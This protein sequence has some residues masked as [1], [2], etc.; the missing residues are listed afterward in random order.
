MPVET[1][2]PPFPPSWPYSIFSAE[3]FGPNMRM[4]RGDTFVFSR[5]VYDANG[6]VVDITGMTVRL[7][8]KYAVTDDDGD[9]VFT[10][11]TGGNGIV[12]TTPASGIYTVTIDPEDTEDLPSFPVNLV[13]DIQLIDGSTV[14][15]IMSGVLTVV[16]DVG[17]T[18]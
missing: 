16:P 12:L 4:V 8:A 9:A 1:A 2:D 7:T 17:V 15:T 5:T 13:Y 14:N 3:G 10:L 11:S 18:A 6:D